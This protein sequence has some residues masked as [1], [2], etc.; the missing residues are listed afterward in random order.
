MSPSPSQSKPTGVA[1]HGGS[2]ISFGVIE[3]LRAL[4]PKETLELVHRLDRDTSGL[5]IIAKKRSAL[6][7]LQALM[8]ESALLTKYTQT[9]DR[10]SAFE[11]LAKRAEEAAKP[12]ESGG[13]GGWLGGLLGG[14]DAAPTTGG[15]GA[16]KGRTTPSLGEKIATSAA[17]S[18]AT[19]VGRQIG[20][21]IVRGVLGS[22]LGGRR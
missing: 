8:R 16:P 14:G 6:L 13:I 17:R 7:E 21:A 10:E 20:T 11:M 18:V 1:S 4:R 2:G 3:T 12:A 15:R 22:L 5:M 19:S 9:V